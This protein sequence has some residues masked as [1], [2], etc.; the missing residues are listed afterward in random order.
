MEKQ[1]RKKL[2]IGFTVARWGV[3]LCIGALLIAVAC[4]VSALMKEAANL[5]KTLMIPFAMCIAG[6]IVFAVG[7]VLVGL[8]ARK[9]NFHSSEPWTE[10]ERWFVS[11]MLELES[12]GAGVSFYN[13]VARNTDGDL[14]TMVGGAMAS[15]IVGKFFK[16]G[17]KYMS[18]S[19]LLNRLPIIVSAAAAIVFLIVSII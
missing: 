14:D 7:R 2:K 10:E 17:E 8:Q 4:I 12:T 1:T 13:S 3:D 5:I 18:R 19:F 16:I 9:L 11:C 6:L 15:M